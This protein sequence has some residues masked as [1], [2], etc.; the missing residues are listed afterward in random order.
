M[1]MY[2]CHDISEKVGA[3][4]D[5]ELAVHERAQIWLHLAIC[6]H[7]RRFIRQFAA[8]VGLMRL[9]A[10][11]EPDDLQAQEDVIRRLLEHRDRK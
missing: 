11:A 2:S 4:I 10:A 3:H 1:K 5:G 6:V 9:R 7:C 8:T